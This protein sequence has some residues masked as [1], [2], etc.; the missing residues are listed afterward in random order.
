[1]LKNF[2][3]LFFHKP[4]KLSA[5]FNIWNLSLG[6]AASAYATIHCAVELRDAD[7]RKDLS[8]IETPTLILHGT[9][10]RICVFDLAKKMNEGVKESQ[11]VAVEVQIM[12]SIMKSA[13]KSTQSLCALLG[14]SLMIQQIFLLYSY[15][16]KRFYICV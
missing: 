4:E 15:G 8:S 12:V 10:D 1:M 7:L 2:S 14:K 13:K 9:D 11:L 6:L 3:Q 16:P 5:E